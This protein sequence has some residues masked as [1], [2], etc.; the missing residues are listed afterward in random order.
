MTMSKRIKK[1][2]FVTP[3]RSIFT[4]YMLTILVGGFLLWLPI[5]QNPGV[6][7]S[8][9]DALFISLSQ[10]SSTGLTPV[11]QRDTFNILGGII[12]ILILEIGA[13]GIMMLV[14]SYWVIIGKKISLKERSLIA[15]EQNQFTVKGIIKLITNAMIAVGIIQIIY[16][17]IMTIYIYTVQPFEASMGEALF[18][19]VYLA[20]AGFAN[21]G[22]DFLPGNQSFMVF[23]GYYLPQILTMIIIFTG[24]VGFWPLAEL[25]LFIKSK[26]HR[27]HYK[28]SFISRMLI[29]SHFIFWIVSAAIYFIME[30]ENSMRGQP[31]LDIL[32][33]V[34]FMTNNARSAGFYN[35]DVTNWAEATRLMFSM[36]M[37]IGAAP[38]SSGG[39]IRMTTFFLLTAGLISFGR[40]RKQVFFAGKAIKDQAV[41]KA[42]MVFAL[43]IILVMTSTLF[44][45]IIEPNRWTIMEIGFEVASAFGTVGLSLGL[46][47]Y[48][49]VYSKM[50]IMVNMFVGRIG[51]L[52]AVAMLENKKETTNVVTYVEMDMLVG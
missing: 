11:S 9:I 28:V 7:L 2:F 21:A 24:G 49:G 22:F 13:V 50:I 26:I 18:Q 19:A 52:T 1:I 43:A 47:P 23:N 51:I 45:S 39:G 10:I 25:V 3:A 37:F 36:L 38:N 31:P 41:K 6:N 14:A 15:S 35:T 33:N 29:V 20:A 30:Y 34:L 42:Y 16:I 46:I 44:I 4:I 40:H 32:M 8:F 27:K 48:I 12:S 17:I 5:A